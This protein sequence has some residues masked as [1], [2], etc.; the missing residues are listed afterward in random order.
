MKLNQTDYLVEFE[1]TDNPTMFAIE[2]VR[3]HKLLGMDLH[4]DVHIGTK[5]MLGK[6]SQDC[7]KACEAGNTEMVSGSN[8]LPTTMEEGR[9]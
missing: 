9:I 5:A 4:I 6:V 3:V 2:L 1:E 7:E 8:K